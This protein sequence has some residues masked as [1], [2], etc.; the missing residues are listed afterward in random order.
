MINE[1]F[2][3]YKKELGAWNLVY[4][5]MKYRGGILYIVLI[6][7]IALFGTWFYF[8]NHIGITL[9]MFLLLGVVLGLINEHNKIIIKRV[10]D[11]QIKEDLWGGKSFHKLRLKKLRENLVEKNIYSS[12]QLNLLTDR[13]YREAENRKFTGFFI[14]GL[15][16]AMFLPVWNNAIS[17]WFK[18]SQ[19]ASQVINIIGTLVII[20]GYILIIT[21]IIKNIT[22]DIFNRDSNRLKR[23]AEMLEDILLEF[24]R[25]LV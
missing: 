14:P 9:L 4:K 18:N 24:P 6:I 12:E 17:W 21:K 10:H 5:H 3:Y 22:F 16:L 23:L 15:A 11:I 19:S 25:T 8:H 7:V 20:I 1:L 2:E 13:T